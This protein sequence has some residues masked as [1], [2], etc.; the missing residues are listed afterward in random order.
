V[1]VVLWAMFGIALVVNQGGLDAAWA[2]LRSL[3]IVAQGVVALLVLPVAAGLW[4]WE[5]GWPLVVRL[6]VV[7][8][9]AY[10]TVAVFF[11][12][13]LFGGRL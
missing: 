8:G 2:W 7:G 12:R 9:L 13:D 5:T 1:F 3:P 11:P 10:A 6:A 4:V